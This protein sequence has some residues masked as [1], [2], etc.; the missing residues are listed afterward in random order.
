MLRGAFTVLCG[1]SLLL[2]CGEPETS[3]FQLTSGSGGSVDTRF[4]PPANQVRTTEA[5]ACQK[6]YDA[7]IDRQLTIKC[8]G[9]VQQC[10]GMVRSLYGTA[11]QEYD[12]GT[13]AG[14]VAYFGKATTCEELNP[15]QCVLVAYPESAPKGCP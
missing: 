2:A 14:C 4:F 11:C 6:I 12:A 8:V 10:P 1:S 3:A 7:L 5:D 13:V 9:T 15:E